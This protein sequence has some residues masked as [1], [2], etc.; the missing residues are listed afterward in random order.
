MIARRALIETGDA[1]VVIAG[2]VESMTR[3]PWV[4]PKP[5]PRLPGRQRHRRVDHARLAAGQPDRCP[6][7]GRSRSA[8]RNEQLQQTVRRSRANGRTSSRCART[9]CADAAWNDGFY[10][11]LVVA[12]RGRRPDP[13][14]EHPRR[15]R[16]LEALAAL[17]PSFR[18]DGTITAGNASPLNDGASAVLLG[19][20]EAAD[21]IGRDPSRASPAAARSRS[22]RRTSATPRSRRP[23][24]RWPAPASAGTTSAPSSSTRRSPCSRSPAS[25]RG[26]ST[27]RLVNARGGAIAIGHPLGASGGAHPRHAR[28]AAAAE[29][30]SAGASPR[31][32]SASD[33]GWPSSWR[34]SPLR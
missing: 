23:T 31:S 25:T 24:A 8:R 15:T 4:L 33:R 3:A 30:A 1:D 16:T 18:A 5:R 27:R 12:G 21:A 19:S 26:R 13:R 22:N 32:A 29:R 28:Q 17:K 9:S 6:T 11:D 2:G 10:D 34:T 14:R 7:S 20:S